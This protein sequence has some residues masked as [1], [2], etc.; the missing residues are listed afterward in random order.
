MAF[1]NFKKNV[2]VGISI[3]PERGLE[4]AQ[5]DYDSKVI[6]KYGCRELAYDNIKKTI[7]D[8]D[9]LKETMLDL[10]TELEIPK[11]SEI[12]LNLPA[13]L[14]RIGDY[15]ASLTIEQV[16]SLIEEELNTH[17]IFHDSDPC[18]ATACLPSS[19][20]Q[21][22][23]VAYSA[24]QK[25]MLIEIAM[26][27]KE[28]GYK[29]VGIDTSVNSSLNALVYNDRINANSNTSWVMLLVEN[30]FCR[31]L[32]MLGKDYVDCYEE[33]VTIAEVLGDEENYSTVIS[34]VS[35]IIKN[36]PSEYLY[37][38]SKTNIIDA[39]KLAQ[40]L[41]YKTPIIHQNDNQ[42]SE[43]MIME[44]S[45]EVSD[46][47]ASKISLDVIGA[48][49]YREY[50]ENIE[51]KFNLFNE[52]LGDVYILEQPFSMMLGTKKIIFSIE[53]M[54]LASIILTVA[55][56]LIVL[57]FII[58]LTQA[59]NIK[60]DKI[61]KFDNSIKRIQSFLDANKD[62]SSELFDEGDEIRVGLM[63]NKDFYTYYTIVGSEIPQKLWLTHIDFGEYITIEGQSSNLESIYVYFRN[64]KDYN[65]KSNLKLQ[66]LGLASSS[67]LKTLSEEEAFDTN[68]II[69]SISSEYYEFRISNAPESS[70][71]NTT[72]EKSKSNNNNNRLEPLD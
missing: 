47:V 41:K 34:A 26:Q 35:P 45:P 58:P 42:Y 39:E 44:F 62:V 72:K 24:L 10:L 49:I 2:V 57:C 18:L 64:I 37:I 63:Q 16:Q 11:G 48:A 40:S 8:F 4:V 6:L 67:N 51:I 66:K 14:F 60:K 65:P 9:I 38:V 71:V 33:P 52:S 53:N 54:I 50:C 7:S 21:N 69:N 56:V 27:I 46:E 59:I 68:S 31:V 5:I 20:I 19:T 61:A 22:N 23:H 1:L 12:V 36:I 13:V 17:T 55:V 28:I 32:Y 29:L 15:P 25:T 30:G 70:F 43:A 3:S